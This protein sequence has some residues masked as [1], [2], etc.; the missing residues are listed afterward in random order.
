MKLSHPCAILAVAF[1]GLLSL[2]ECIKAD[3]RAEESEVRPLTITQ[4][5]L[6]LP[7]EWL[8]SLAGIIG[9]IDPSSFRRWWQPGVGLALFAVA[10][11][12]WLTLRP[13]NDRDWAPE[14]TDTPWAK[15]CG[16]QVIIHNFRN[17]DYQTETD[18][19]A[20]WETKSV[21]LSKLCGLDL[22]MN[23]WGSPHIAH[24]LLSFDFGE[25]GRVCTSIETRRERHESYSAIRGFFRQYELYYVIGDERDLVGLRTNYRD[26][27]VYLY[28]LAKASP[29]RLRALFL[30]YL[31]AANDLRDRPRW[32]HAAMSNCTTNIRLNAQASGFATAWN[33]RMLVNGHLD[34]LLYRRG[35]I[36]SALAFAETKT[37][38]QIKERAR[39]VESVLDFSERIRIP[40]S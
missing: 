2:A 7:K 12:W 16:D 4:Q 30:T 9:A 5:E 8:R 14:Y 31:K 28:R 13:S 29:E 35:I 40:I 15:V 20:R 23:Y 36:P 6:P 37:R 10:F 33:W 38:A 17:F 18:F 26:Q 34:E 3:P 1:I 22:F 24:T 32:Y 25:E 39:R 11:V 19:M 21:H 27:D